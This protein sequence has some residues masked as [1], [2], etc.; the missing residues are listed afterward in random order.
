MNRPK[1]PLYRRVNTKTHRVSHDHGG[2]FKNDRNKKRESLQGSKGAMHGKTKRG[3][4]YT[5]LFKF[6]LSRVGRDWDQTFSEAK[7]RL[8]K[9]DPIFW[10]VALNQED[11]Q[12]YVR[13]GESS[14]F[15]GMFVDDIGILQLTNDG[16][17]AKDLTPFCN[18]CTHT[19][20]GQLFGSE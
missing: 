14:Y 9:P 2:D 1:K 8:D 7:A 6:L 18:C 13:V 12:D 3:L 10:L 16:L 15:S 20:N 11:K 17:K 4:D 19:L 5:P